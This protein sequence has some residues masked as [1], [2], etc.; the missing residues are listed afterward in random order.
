M[1]ALGK[2]RSRLHA[3]SHDDHGILVIALQQICL[4]LGLRRRLRTRPVGQQLQPQRRNES[5]EVCRVAFA[6]LLLQDADLVLLLGADQAATLDHWH[7]P[8]RVRALAMIAV[9]PRPGA[10]PIDDAAV[11]AIALPLLE[12]SSSDIRGRVARG[13]SIDGLVTP[14]VEALIVAAGLYGPETAG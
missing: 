12:V 11:L 2:R 5:R 7:E 14:A 4:H 8:E 3:D 13:D 10:G 6:R 1:I 9:A